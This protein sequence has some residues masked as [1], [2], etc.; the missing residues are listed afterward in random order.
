MREQD[1]YRPRWAT[2]EEPEWPV[3]PSRR[4]RLHAPQHSELHP[5]TRAS[6]LKDI[7]LY[8]MSVSVYPMRSFRRPA[9]ACSRIVHRRVSD[10]QTIS[11]IATMEARCR[12]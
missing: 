10:L 4:S 8:W 9:W 2:Q 5:F 11:S 1:P 12:R 3:T 6:V 7:S